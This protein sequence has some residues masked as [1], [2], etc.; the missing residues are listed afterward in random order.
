MVKAYRFPC[1]SGSCWRQERLYK[2][3]DGVKA[4]AL[5]IPPHLEA[6][7]SYTGSL[8]RNGNW[9]PRWDAESGLDLTIGQ[10][11]RV[12]QGGHTCYMSQIETIQGVSRL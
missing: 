8:A 7:V 6:A 9:D 1:V 11:N 2:E 10:I 12:Q 3:H 5:V 4:R